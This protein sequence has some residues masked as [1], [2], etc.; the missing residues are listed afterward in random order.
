MKLEDLTLKEF[1]IVCREHQKKGRDC[2]TCSLYKFCNYQLTVS[3]PSGWK[4]EDSINVKR[5]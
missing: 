4:L 5:D 3:Y 2:E 1:S